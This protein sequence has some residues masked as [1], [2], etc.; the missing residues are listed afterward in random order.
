MASFSDT[1]K[2]HWYLNLV[3][4][5]S[6]AEESFK[7]KEGAFR[8]HRED[9]RHVCWV[10][11]RPNIWDLMILANREASSLCLQF[12]CPH[13]VP[14]TVSHTG[15]NWMWSLGAGRST[16][17]TDMWA[18]GKNRE[19]LDRDPHHK[20]SL[21]S[22]FQNTCFLPWVFHFPFLTVIFKLRSLSIPLLPETNPQILMLESNITIWYFR[23][24]H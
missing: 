1:R 24:W 18:S 19:G 15:R 3:S 7:Y 10:K 23:K 17:P 9:T 4:Q 8:Q 6:G 16:R 22:V 21:T 5:D 2:A 11:A 13:Q 14:T 20:R 12:D